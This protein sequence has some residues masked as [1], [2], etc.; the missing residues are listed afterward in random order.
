MVW[1]VFFVLSVVVLVLTNFLS[2]NVEALVPSNLEAL[3]SILLSLAI[4]FGFG[5]FYSL[6]WKQQLFSKKAINVFIA[7]FI[8]NMLMFPIVTIIQ[9]YSDI[10]LEVNEPFLALIIAGVMFVMLISIFN[11]FSI[12]FYIGLY[13]YKKNFESLALVQRPCWKLFSFYSILPLLSFTLFALTKW[14]HFV[15]Y[16]FVDYFI[17]LSGIYET[18]LLIGFA[19]NLKIFNKLFWQ[20]TSIPYVILTLMSLFWM[21]DTF[22]QDFHIKEWAFSNPI[23]VAESVVLMLILFYILYQYA[24]KRES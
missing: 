20:I 2:Y 12:P 19:W 6:G 3:S 5:I 1:K 17:L 11:L 15:L 22:N 24:Y 16:N 4:I 9:S 10:M 21:S 14:N 13:K 7:I 8:I 23:T 18:I